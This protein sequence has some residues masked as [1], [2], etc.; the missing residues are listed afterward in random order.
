MLKTITW[1]VQDVGWR[2]DLERGDDLLCAPAG[3]SFTD[4]HLGH[5]QIRPKNLFK[6][7]IL[8]SS[9]HNGDADNAQ[10]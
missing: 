7:E 3:H 2:V 1:I 10:G 4:L 9:A 5:L 8:F 6:F